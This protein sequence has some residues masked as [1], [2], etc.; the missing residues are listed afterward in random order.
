MEA[1]VIASTNTWNAYNAFGGRS[2]Y[3]MASQMIEQPIVNSK[4]DFAA[5]EEAGEVRRMEEH[6][7]VRA[8]IVRPAEAGN[9]VPE[10][11]ECTDTIEGRMACALASPPSGG[12]STGWSAKDSPTTSI[13]TP[14]STTARSISTPIAS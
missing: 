10:N 7:G 9:L 8:A 12:C 2:R 14:S 13:R 1:A 6:R 11:V 3:I 4:A 5:A